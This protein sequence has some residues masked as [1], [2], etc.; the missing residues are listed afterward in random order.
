MLQLL[1]F[2]GEDLRDAW[3]NLTEIYGIPRAGAA[4]ALWIDFLVTK[5]TVQYSIDFFLREGPSPPRCTLGSAVLTEFFP[6]KRLELKSLRGWTKAEE[7]GDSVL[8]LV[9][10]RPSLKILY[11]G[12]SILS[13]PFFK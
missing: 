7:L 1:A 12:L 8:K 10:L 6:E 5:Y 3:R 9:S 2:Q 11:R 4:R 13:N